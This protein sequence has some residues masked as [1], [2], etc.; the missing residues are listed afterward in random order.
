MLALPDDI[1]LPEPRLIVPVMVDV[2]RR[3]PGLNVLNTEAAAAALLL[4]AKMVL[5]DDGTAGPFRI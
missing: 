1:G 2:Q 5:S 3:H 4:G